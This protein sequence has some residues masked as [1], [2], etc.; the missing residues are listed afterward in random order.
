MAGCKIKTT[1][2]SKK[3][4]TFSNALV[5]TNEEISGAIDVKIEASDSSVGIYVIIVKNGSKAPTHEEIFNHVNYSGV[6]I[7]AYLTGS[8]EI[9]QTILDLEAATK[10]DVYVTLF[11]N[12]EFVEKYYK[13]T[14][15]TKEKTEQSSTE[16]VELKDLAAFATA[17]KEIT[18]TAST[19]KGSIYYLVVLSTAKAP[20]KE[21]IVAQ[22]NYDDVTVIAHGISDNRLEATISGL[23]DSTSYIIYA[24]AQ[25]ESFMSDI[26]KVTIVTTKAPVPLVTSYS[27]VDKEEYGSILITITTNKVVTTYYKISKTELNLTKEDMLKET[28]TLEREI[29]ATVDTGT[30]YFVYLYSKTIEEDTD[31][32]CRTI[33]T[34]EP[35]TI[36]I[37]LTTP[38]RKQIAITGESTRG[39]IHYIVVLSTAKAP[40]IEQI[41]AHENYDD[42]KIIAYGN[43]VGNELSVVING[44]TDNQSYTVY[45]FAKQE[46]EN[47]DIVS[48]TQ[49]TQEV[50]EELSVE[51]VVSDGADL[52][53]IKIDVSANKAVTTYYKISKVELNLTKEDMLQEESFIGNTI[54][55]GGFDDDTIYYVSLY[56]KT[57]N[58]DNIVTCKSIKTK[59]DSVAFEVKVILRKTNN[60]RELELRITVNKTNAS[61]WYILSS[62]LTMQYTKEEIMMNGVVYSNDIL[63]QALEDNT[64]YRIYVYA[65]TSTKE[66]E[67]ITA[68]ASTLDETTLFA[69][70]FTGDWNKPGLYEKDGTEHSMPEHVKESGNTLS[71]ID[72]GAVANDNTKD[73]YQAFKDAIAAATEGD[74]IYIP[75]GKYYFT[76]SLK[77]NSYYAHIHLKSGIT[78]RGESKN[79][80]ILVSCFS[81]TENKDLQTTVIGVTN[82]SNVA[83]KNVTVTSNTMDLTYDNSNHNASLTIW[84]GPKYGITVA[85]YN[86]STIAEKT[87]NVLIDGVIVEKF[88]RS[89]IRISMA[90]EVVV[91]NS[92]FKNATALGGGGCGYGVTIQGKA[93]NVDTTDT[94]FD[95]KFN[96]VEDCLFKGSYLRHGVLIQYF[97]HNNFV[98]NNTFEDILLDS[99]DLH[100]EDEYSNE[101]CHNTILNTRSGAGIGLGNTGATHDA[102]GRNNFIHNNIIEGGSKGI[103]ID[104]NTP[105]TVIYKN[106]IK[107]V[108]TG[109]ICST[110]S[111]TRIIQNGLSNIRDEA[112]IVKCGFAWENASLGIP[113]G[114][115]IKQNSVSNCG[116]GILINSRAVDSIIEENV[117]EGIQE[118]NQ[119]IDN[120][121]SFVLQDNSVSIAIAKND[122]AFTY[123]LEVTTSVNNVTVYYVI[124][125]DSV[126]PAWQI[127]LDQSSSKSLSIS[128]EGLNYGTTYYVHALCVASGVVS[129]VMS[130]SFE[131][132]AEPQTPFTLTTTTAQGHAKYAQINLTFQTNKEDATIHYFYSEI[133]KNKEDIKEEDF[134]YCTKDTNVTLTGL[135]S[136]TEYYIYSYASLENERTSIVSKSRTTTEWTFNR[137]STSTTTINIYN[138]QD[139]YAYITFL[140]DGLE[141]N[142]EVKKGSTSTSA[143]L[144][145]WA[146]IDLNE[147]ISVILPT[148]N[149]TF[150][151]Q[152][153]T[154]YNM[155]I[156][157]DTYQI[158]LFQ[159]FR[160]SF[161]NTNFV[162][163]KVVC[164]KDTI[165]EGSNIY[166]L[167]TAAALFR[168]VM[169]NVHIRD[170]YVESKYIY[171][172]SD[173]K[174]GSRAGGLIG[175]MTQAT[176][177]GA[178]TT[179]PSVNN[180]SVINTKVIGGKNVGGVIGHMDYQKGST[181]EMM[182]SNIYAETEVTGTD[183]V[184]G[185]IA[186]CRGSVKNIVTKSILHYETETRAGYVI[187][188]MQNNKDVVGLNPNIS[189]IISY[190]EGAALRNVSTGNG[191]VNIDVSSVLCPSKK[192]N[193]QTVVSLEDMT[194]DY[195]K[196]HTSFFGIEVSYWIMIENQ[197]VLK[198]IL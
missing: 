181:V 197:I 149:G 158:G 145:L 33:T 170:S 41:F 136:S 103:T 185:A 30:A 169:D 198:S 89:G 24:L 1:Q 60:L 120:T 184:G 35:L 85:S 74:T 68:T 190:T 22:Q 182:V 39:V 144:T 28:S 48:A 119:I 195:L 52:G 192:G 26:K 172:A 54:T 157:S 66:S 46:I 174:G 189:S 97:S 84:T 132:T 88:L 177:S 148:Y 160:G 180:C 104:L 106:S 81:E 7:V 135:K 122:E 137:G 142:G 113:T 9:K 175:R 194:E 124:T 138:T 130:V 80:V 168:G 193:Y 150:D 187:G 133:E 146:D 15:L 25:V 110:S 111:G 191:D 2:T 134:I 20:T 127:L 112:I 47:S 3:G 161:L 98:H 123:N 164:T 141:I 79:G 64:K 16:S 114:Y 143:K 152:G 131:T 19:S 91:K 42:V 18:I 14:C 101:I 78:L 77:V 105:N 40:S 23:S 93:H 17:R 50:V 115:E 12:E 65:K 61:I 34:K 176:S 171:T 99:I 196:E 178:Q 67:V 154:I 109:I 8:G 82:A 13:T 121:N 36:N 75:N 102:T 63:L 140:N 56:S 156:S 153:Y 95:A 90:Q 76:T 162:N 87:K 167:G 29:S 6:E 116:K 129:K 83:I 51:Y 38:Q 49:K 147:E 173:D 62:D 32:I 11:A 139:F 108:V 117:F 96:V 188:Y 126:A 100:G 70:Y 165:P 53:Q 27:V 5:G 159:E 163:A 92:T 125:D 94:L 44:L 128:L 4:P 31:V 37:T 166:A 118:Q 186:Y 73:N 183:Y 107:D 10:Y 59:I 55:L 179:Q 57:A 86:N 151:G 72:Y 71:V 155:N 69:D 58:E 21:Q 45:A 43:S